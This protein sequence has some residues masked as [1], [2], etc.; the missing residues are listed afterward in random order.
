MINW[1][2]VLVFCV[3]VGRR[4]LSV[5]DRGGPVEVSPAASPSTVLGAPLSGRPDYLW[6]VHMGPTTSRRH[7]Q[8]WV[9][10]RLLCRSL[11]FNVLLFCF[12]RAYASILVYVSPPHPH[13]SGHQYS[14][15]LPV[16]DPLPSV[17]FVN[18][19]S[20][21][22]GNDFCFH[23]FDCDWNNRD[24]ASCLTLYNAQEDITRWPVH[25]HHMYV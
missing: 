5:V 23:A 19:S 11:L 21:P 13:L 3:C 25:V 8:R 4:R 22:L 2:F 18:R 6:P 17:H 14:R 1:P 9:F 12:H 16:P 20:S 24:F 10:K 15:Q 7:W